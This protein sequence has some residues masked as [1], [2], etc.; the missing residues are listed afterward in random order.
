MRKPITYSECVF[1]ALVI[2][3]AMCMR[4]DVI[5]GLFGSTMFVYVISQTTLLPKKVSEHNKC[6]FDFLYSFV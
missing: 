3:H 1:V 5:C 2:Q 6:V 4:H